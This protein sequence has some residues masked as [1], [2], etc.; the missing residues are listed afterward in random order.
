MFV[1]RRWLWASQ[2]STMTKISAAAAAV[3]TVWLAS[4]GGC[5]HS[6]AAAAG[7]DSNSFANICMCEYVMALTSVP[8]G[9]CLRVLND[10]PYAYPTTRHKG[11]V[12]DGLDKEGTWTWRHTMPSP[13]NKNKHSFKK[14]YN[15]ESASWPLASMQ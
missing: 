4:R 1:V 5:S 14:L 7:A 11:C 3:A 8:T 13:L 6:F 10:S 9:A 2:M 12:E 15:S